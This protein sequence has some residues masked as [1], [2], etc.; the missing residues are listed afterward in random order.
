MIT[1]CAS[2]RSSTTSSAVVAT[3]SPSITV[4]PTGAAPSSAPNPP[5]MT[6]TNER[7]IAVHMM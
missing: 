7:F 4:P 2:R 3:I 5:R 6:E 1:D